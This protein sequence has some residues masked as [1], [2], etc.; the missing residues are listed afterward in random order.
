[1]IVVTTDVTIAETI[2]AETIDETIEG[3][4]TGE[5]TTDGMI[6]GEMIVVTTTAVMID[7]T[8]TAVMIVAVV[9][10]VIVVAITV[11]HLHLPRLVATHQL[12]QPHRLPRITLLLNPTDHRTNPI[13]W[14]CGAL[15]CV[16]VL[17]SI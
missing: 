6:A 17:A 10:A 5:I 7:E 13:Q 4:T 12:P 8:T 11:R 16:C 2:D 9:V 1:M 3:I 14:S 15:S